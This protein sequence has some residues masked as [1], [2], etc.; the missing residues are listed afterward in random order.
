MEDKTNEQSGVYS[1]RHYD[2]TGSADKATYTTGNAS[3]TTYYTKPNNTD[4]FGKDKPRKNKGGAGRVFG[5]IFATLG[6]GILF[7]LAAG[8]TAFVLYKTA[9]SAVAGDNTPSVSQSEE[10]KDD[11]ISFNKKKAK[12]EESDVSD[13]P[14][15]AFISSEIESDMD[16]AAK[17]IVADVSEMVDQTMPSIVSITGKYIVTGQSFWGQT[18]SQET[19]GSGSGIII[20]RDDDK[21]YIATNNHVVEDSEN[22]QV[23]FIDGTKADATI[24][25]TDADM[26]LAVIMVDID[27]LESRTIDEIKVADLGNSDDIKIG[28]PA[29]VIGNSLGYGQTVTYGVISA[30][31]RTLEMDDGTVSKGLIQTDAAINPGNSGGALLNIAGEVIGISSSKIGGATVDGVGFAI[32]ISSA[33]PILSDIVT[34]TERSKVSDSKQGYLGIGGQ[35]VTEEV[36]NMYGL[37]VGVLVRQV[38]EGTGAEESGLEQGDVITAIGNKKVESMEDLREELQYYSKNDVVQVTVSR[39]SDGLYNEM[40]LDVRL[41]DK[42]A[43]D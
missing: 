22:L 43:L 7:G 16:D 23:Q 42:D 10:S 34:R 5:R 32:P 36:A 14:E 28:E 39:L 12:D 31:D 2:Y 25:G 11:K 30:V 24:K 18:Y 13:I 19:E 6:L 21:L 33:E 15:E 9:G 40:T 27:D 38:Y 4:T 20:A 8:V 1:S 35:T 37:P 41:V 17:I 26:D 29:V 3:E